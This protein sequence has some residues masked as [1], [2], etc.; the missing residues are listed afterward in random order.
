M[1]ELNPK[2]L[3]IIAVFV[4]LAIFAAYMIFLVYTWQ[5]LQNDRGAAIAKVDKLLDRFPVSDAKRS[6]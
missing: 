5:Q 2:V 4:M 1:I 6:E 3:S